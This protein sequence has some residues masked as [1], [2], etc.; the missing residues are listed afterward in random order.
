MHSGQE[1]KE[2]GTLVLMGKKVPYQLIRS[3]RRRKTLGFRIDGDAKLTVI[4]PADASQEGIVA[5]TERNAGWILDKIDEVLRRQDNLLN[6]RVVPLLGRSLLLRLK[7]CQGGEQIGC[8]VEESW[9]DVEIPQAVMEEA[10][11]SGQLSLLIGQ[12][13]KRWYLEQAKISVERRVVFWAEQFGVDVPKVKITNPKKRWGSCDSN[14]LLRINW[15]VILLPIPLFD[16]VLA[17]EVA[18]ILHRD[19]SAAFWN[20]MSEV[21]PECR[22]L[23]E[24]MMQ[25]KA[26]ADPL[27]QGK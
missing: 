20:K 27:K 18:H 19:H 16:Y 24:A 3:T 11:E 2:G 10:E 25:F 14:N 21:M 5:G 7:T 26:N 9:F 1:L 22:H 4:A 15:R 8:T 13:L 6:G 17:H 12:M 23:D